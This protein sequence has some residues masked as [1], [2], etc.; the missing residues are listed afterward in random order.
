MVVYI[1]I[2]DV[3]VLW[4]FFLGDINEIYDFLKIAIYKGR[5][6]KYISFL[7]KI[8]IYPYQK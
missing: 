5:A 2:S 1:G 7:Y 3:G 6:H 4:K 8:A